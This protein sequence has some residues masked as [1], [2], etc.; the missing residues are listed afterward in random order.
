MIQRAGELKGAE[1]LVN[2]AISNVGKGTETIQAVTS[3]TSALTSVWGLWTTATQVLGSENEELNATMTKMIT[4]IT[5]LSSLSSLQAALSKTEA[6]YRAA[7]N[8]VQ[9]VGINQTLAE[10]KAIAAKNAVQGAS[11]ILTKAAAAA[12]WL[13]NAALAANPVVLVAAAV[14]GLVAGVVALMNA[15]NSNTEAQERATRAM[16]A[17]NRAAEAS[18]YVLDQI[19]TKRNTLSKAEEIRGKREIENLKANHATSEQIAEAQLKTAN[20]LREI[21]MSA[22]RQRQMLQRMSST[23]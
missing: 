12:T 23:P 21:E 6:T 8:L 22:A 20:K 1:D 13:W 2:T 15:F 14:G 4:I 19:E 5:A 18:T 16:E 7:S 10:T 11:N 9:L 17:Y 3:A